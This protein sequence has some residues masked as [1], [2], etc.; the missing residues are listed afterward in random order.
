MFAYT[1]RF[2][3]RRKRFGCEIRVRG[4]VHRGEGEMK[5]A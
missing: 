2:N 3:I 1:E 4:G 5:D